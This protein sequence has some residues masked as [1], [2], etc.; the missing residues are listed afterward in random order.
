MVWTVGMCRQLSAYGVSFG[1]AFSYRA[2]QLTL[3]RL[4]L[5]NL[6]HDKGYLLVPGSGAGWSEQMVV[7]RLLDDVSDC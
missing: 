4:S 1:V 6:R 7:R 3:S 5:A 2:Y